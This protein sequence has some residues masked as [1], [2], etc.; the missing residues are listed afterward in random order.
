VALLSHL[1]GTAVVF[2]AL[3][4]LI[5]LTSWFFAWLQTKHPL[6]PDVAAPIHQFEVGSLY[7]DEAVCAIMLVAGAFRFCREL[8]QE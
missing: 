8:I 7:L 3:F 6:P 2:V 5:W 4:T 1:A